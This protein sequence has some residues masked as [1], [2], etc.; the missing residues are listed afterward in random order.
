MK[1][2]SF[3]LLPTF[4]NF[5]KEFKLKRYGNNRITSARREYGV[6]SEAGLQDADR[7]VFGASAEACKAQGV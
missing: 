5:A 7:C 4:R 6:E 2:I 1:W 3:V